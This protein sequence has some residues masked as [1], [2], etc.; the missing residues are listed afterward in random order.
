MLQMGTEL[1]WIVECPERRYLRQYIY[2]RYCDREARLFSCHFYA[3]SA[4]P[5]FGFHLCHLSIGGGPFDNHFQIFIS[6][7]ESI[8]VSL[9]M[10]P[11]FIPIYLGVSGQV[12]LKI[13]D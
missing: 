7:P 1:L 2:P 8:S 6:I 9:L 10:I 13:I 3:D 11:G 4:H 12:C 5:A